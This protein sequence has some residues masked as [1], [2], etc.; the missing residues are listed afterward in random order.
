M[1]NMKTVLIVVF[2]VVALILTGA[3]S[4]E[5]MVGAPRAAEQQNILKQYNFP[6]NSNAG[7]APSAGFSNTAANAP[8]V[9]PGDDVNGM[10]QTLDQTSDD[11]GVSDIQS[12]QKDASGL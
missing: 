1:K 3:L 6:G 10:L 12:L 8:V 2:V 4:Y 5:A 9:Q 11:A 7:K